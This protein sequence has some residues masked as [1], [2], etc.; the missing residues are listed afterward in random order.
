MGEDLGV[1]VLAKKHKVKQGECI[2]S[3]ADKYG[4]FWETVWN[5]AENSELKQ[6]RGDPNVLQTGDAVYIPDKEVKEENCATEETHRFRKKGIP[7]K[8]VVRLLIDD[9]PLENVAYRLKVDDQ[10]MPDDEINGKTDGDGYAK[11]NIPPGAKTAEIVVEDNDKFNLYF[12]FNFGEIDPLETD[13]GKRARLH[14]LGYNVDDLDD[15]VKQFQKDNDLQETDDKD[16]ITAQLKE[17]F[18]Q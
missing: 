7:A 13:A 3:I 12:P 6:Q 14:D 11:E 8:M 16:S 10:W 15:A 1:E 18:G 2:T 9:E 17:L 5:H 4:L